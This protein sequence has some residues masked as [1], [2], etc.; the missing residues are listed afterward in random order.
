[1]RPWRARYNLFCSETGGTHDDVIFYRQDDDEWLLVV[2]AGNARKMWG[3]LQ[4][5]RRS[6]ITLENH[7]GTHALIAIQGPRSVEIVGRLVSPADRESIVA[8]HY[9]FC[10]RTNV[11]GYLCAYGAHRIY[12]RRRFR[13][14]RSKRRRRRVVGCTLRSGRYARTRAVRTRRARRVAARSRDAALRSRARRRH[15]ALASRPRLGGEIWQAVVRGQGR[16]RSAARCRR[17]YAH[18]RIHARRPRAAAAHGLSRLRKNALVGE[19]RS[20]AVGIGTALVDPSVAK[21]GSQIEIE[22]RDKR[23]PATVVKLPFYKRS[24]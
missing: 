19:V 4:A 24:K 1:M 3:I 13:A 11:G 14:V 22:I 9:Y 23:W 8:M 20:G 10:A 2:N 16:A 6:G 7:H 17:L 12:R 15:H 18:R 21:A 5:H